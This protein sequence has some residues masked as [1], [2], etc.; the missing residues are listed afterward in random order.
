MVGVRRIVDNGTAGSAAR[1]VACRSATTQS[2][3]P[4]AFH[5]ADEPRRARPRGRAGSAPSPRPARRTNL[6][7][8]A[9]PT[10]RADRSRPAATRR[11]RGFPS[12]DRRRAGPRRSPR[13]S[14]MFGTAAHRRDRIRNSGRADE[15]GDDDGY[16]PGN[17][18]RHE[19]QE[20]GHETEREQHEQRQCREE[21]APHH[22]DLVGR[23]VRTPEVHGARRCEQRDARERDP[24]RPT[25]QRAD[26]QA[27]PRRAR[28]P[29]RPDR[30]TSSSRPSSVRRSCAS[31]RPSRA[32]PAGALE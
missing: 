14:V 11:P 30:G 17:L 18:L 31:G 29:A 3:R 21:V 16:Q 26:E 27:R 25:N 5:C 23:D 12:C 22:P 15:D 4:A 1:I 13:C 7:T 10:G 28:P 19:P 20:R 32:R 2:V 24:R 9:A 8:S 6:A